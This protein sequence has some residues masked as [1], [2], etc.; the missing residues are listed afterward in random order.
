[1]ITDTSEKGLEDLIVNHLIEQGGYESGRSGDFDRAY[2]LDL[3]KLSHFLEVTQREVYKALPILEEGPQ[4]T[5]FLSR[6]Q[7]EITKR[8]VVDVLRH[9]IK[10]G[11]YVIDL[12]YPMASEG[13][14]KAEKLHQQNIFSLTR[15]LRYSQSA[16]RLALDLALFINGL[17]IMTFELKNRL[18][19]QTVNDAVDQ[20]CRDRDPR[21]P[22]FQF[23]RCAVH[24][25]LDEQ[26]VRMCTELKGKSSWFLPFNKGKDGG[27]GNPLNPDG[28]ATDYLW[29]EILEKK[30]LAN[31]LEN[32]TQ[33]IE[34][35]DDKGRK[36]RN[37]LFPRYHQL[38]VVRKL[39]E[40]AA[41]S[42]AGK[43]YLI[44]HSAGSGKSNSIAYLAHQLIELTK[45][46]KALFDS[47]VVVTDRKVLDRQIQRAIKHFAQV[48]AT[49]GHAERSGDLRR[50]LQSGK[51]IIITTVQKF[52]FILEE[53]SREHKNSDFALIIDEAHS[54]QGGR[55]AAKMNM[56]L[57][58][59][60]HDEDESVEDTINKIMESKKC[61]PMQVILRLQQ[62]R[63][64]KRSRFL[65]SLLKKEIS[66][67]FAPSTPIR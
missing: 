53:M 61:S 10:H 22:L 30:S 47:V 1:M 63:K 58:Q 40:D 26:E 48:S 43:K 46:G 34:I 67:S 29:K 45:E 13:N 64:T 38:D 41:Q 59:T 11:P 50:F 37:Q 27:A 49:V 7:G 32:Y 3:K 14:P 33:I 62:H 60:D 25:A 35:K 28:L 2:A 21:E 12:Y 65:E 5:Q 55:T 52:P 57:S 51:K 20:Y 36:K 8:G 56:A 9:G 18:T 6:L 15:Q 31:I 17:P 39:L 23:G 24:F 42:G 4:K 54:S 19:K 44:Q 16:S 66:L